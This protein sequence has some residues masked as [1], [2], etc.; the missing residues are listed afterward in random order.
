MVGLTREAAARYSFL[1]SMPIILAAGAMQSNKLFQQ[2]T[3]VDWAAMAL[4]VAISG[5]SAFLVIHYFLK[6][7]SRLTM[8]PFVLYRLVLGIVLLFL[9]V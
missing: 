2:A 1:L 8:L 6:L 3:P 9:F 5:I 4:G 7:I